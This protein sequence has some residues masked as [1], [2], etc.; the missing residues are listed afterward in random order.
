[1]T[2]IFQ[3]VEEEVRRERLEKIWKEYGDYI[4]GAVAFIIMG[5]AAFELWR[6]YEQRQQMKASEEFL[7]ATRVMQSG[8]SAY[9]AEMFA[10]LAKTAPGGYAKVAKVQEADS[11]L[12]AGKREEALALFRQIVA[13]SDSGLAAVARLHLAWAL[14]DQV[15]RPEIDTLLDPLTTPGNAWAPMARE[16]LAYADYRGGDTSGAAKTYEAL[17]ADTNNPEGLR[18]RA[19]VMA[20]FLKAGGEQNFGTVPEPPKSQQTAPGNPPAPGGPPSK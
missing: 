6:V 8:Q 1:M 16:I 20:A 15:P 11:L 13:G 3:E 9:A 12:A 17:A 7:A 14:V 4:I 18:Q 5:V 10:K 2:D 19:R